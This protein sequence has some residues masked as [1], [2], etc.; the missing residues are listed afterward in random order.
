MLK[1]KSAN[2][3]DQDNLEDDDLQ[4]QFGSWGKR[5]ICSRLARSHTT[6]VKLS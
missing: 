2:E 1:W 6:V 3:M 4:F 5:D